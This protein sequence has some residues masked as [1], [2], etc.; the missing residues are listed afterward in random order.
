MLTLLL[1]AALASTVNLAPAQDT[2]IYS[3]SSNLSNGAGV[4][5]FAGRTATSSRRRALVAFDLTGIPVGS[6][7][8]SATLHFTL[9]LAPP[10]MDTQNVAIHRLVASWGE[11]GSVALPPG[12]MGVQAEPG[13]A[14]WGQS[15]YPER[16]WTVAGGDFAA[17]A[18]AVTSVGF[19]TGV[20][21]AW[22]STAA[23]VAD[24]Q[25]WV[26]DPT[27]NH[28]WILIG[29]ES[30]STT[31]RRFASREST[32]ETFRPRLMVEYTAPAAGPGAVPDGGVRPGTPLKLSRSGGN[33]SLTWGASCRPAADYAVQAGTLASLRTG[34]YDDVPLACTT[35]GQTSYTTAAPAADS[36]VLV[37]PLEAG[38]AGSRGLDGDGVERPL[39]TSACAAASAAAPVCP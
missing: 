3:E 30:S 36:Y 9:T 11:A 15:S 39:G 27:S 10:T 32:T 12:G 23:M 31:A 35:T 37:L 4:D 19:E 29:N 8:G 26:D 28:G 5:V 2:S 7:V 1:T 13:D 24:V 38:I 17:S 22:G 18:S 34:T 14:T 20:D 6:V 16:N 25:A 21:Y 33:L